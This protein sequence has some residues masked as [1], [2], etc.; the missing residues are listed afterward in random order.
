MKIEELMDRAEKEGIINCEGKHFKVKVTHVKFTNKFDRKVDYFVLEPIND[1]T[2]F[3]SSWRSYWHLHGVSPWW[4]A[5][6]EE[7]FKKS[8][9]YKHSSEE[10][11]E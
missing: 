11:D 7:E 6:E 8:Y 10:E 1:E 3:K 9:W 5:S 2:L 4:L